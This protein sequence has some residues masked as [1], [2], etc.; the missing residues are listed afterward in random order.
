MPA[1]PVRRLAA[2]LVGYVCVAA[3]YA[4]PLPTRLGTS[5]PGPV[6]SD[7]G[8]YLWNL[9]VFRHEIV[10][11]HQYPWFTLEILALGPAVPLTLHNYT[12]LANVIAFPLLPL[13]GTVATFNLLVMLSGVLSALAMY[14]FARRASGDHAAAWVAG[15]VFGFAPFMSA[16]GMEHFSLVQTAPIPLFALLFER[17][18]ARPGPAIAAATGATVAI[19]FLCD[20]YYAVY[21]FLIGAFGIVYPMAVLRPAQSTA[22]RPK[23]VMVLDVALICLAGLIAGMILK[24]GGRF[25]IL[26]IRISM[27]RLYTPVLVVTVLTCVRLWLALRPRMSWSL[28]RLPSLRVA[29]VAGISCM[30]LLS[31]VLVA[32]GAH[33]GE[34]SWI[35]PRVWWRSSAPGLDVIAL[36][37]PNPLHPWFGALFKPLLAG[38]PGGFVENVASVPW[39]LLGTLVAAVA[40]AKSRLPAKW[41]TLTA[42]FGLLSLGPFVHIAGQLT[43]I[44]TPWALLRYLPVVGA[45]RMP[46]RMIAVVMFGLAVLLAFAVRDL[47]RRVRRPALLVAVVSVLLMF[48]MLPAPRPVHAVEVPSFYRMIA[49]DPRPLRVLNLPFGLRDGLSSHGNFNAA[50]QF[51]QTFHEKPLLGGYLSRLQRRDVEYYRRRS[52]TRVLIELSEGRDVP[53][54][55]V[56]AAIA[57][58]WAIENELKVGWVVVNTERVSSDLLAF[59]REA[60]RM[61]FMTAEG[62]FHL[63]RTPLAAAPSGAETAARQVPPP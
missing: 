47:R 3:A 50:Y 44:P 27:T 38:M 13:L 63:Y 26:G 5:L 40:F 59:A 55:R 45:A 1:I 57:R 37:V 25:D 21:C 7:L 14:A 49:A 9:W 23:G 28:P 43:Y 51:Y 4:W 22:S 53:P 41:V 61:E 20:P 31:P 10:A 29:A 24:G 60:F 2:A 39:V 32:M 6:S 42:V 11:H 16:R 58:A 46:T 48:E 8:V 35:S 33:A 18:Q 19:A 36:F 52:V 56:A 12:S 30:A 34:R 15:L 62:E 17:L 54:Q